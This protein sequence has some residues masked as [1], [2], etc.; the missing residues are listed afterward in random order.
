MNKKLLSTYICINHVINVY[1]QNNE[2]INEN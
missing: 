1:H 2:E